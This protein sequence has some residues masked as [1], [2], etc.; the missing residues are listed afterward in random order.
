MRILW[1]R[2]N[3]IFLCS[4]LPCLLLLPFALFVYLALIGSAV[5]SVRLLLA[6]GLY[7]LFWDSLLGTPISFF[8]C[9]IALPF[10]ALRKARK[11]L[12]KRAFAVC[13]GIKICMFCSVLYLSSISPFWIKG[14]LFYDLLQSC[15]QIFRQ[16]LLFLPSKNKP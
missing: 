5:C 14:F 12:F 6:I 10:L 3:R 13:H 7:L 9:R 4:S 8:G 2:V 16:T 1:H 11:S 15:M